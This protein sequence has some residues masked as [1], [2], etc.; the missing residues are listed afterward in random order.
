MG[1]LVFLIVMAILAFVVINAIRRAAAGARAAVNSGSTV[2]R[3]P[4]EHNLQQL[5]KLEA[6]V[7]ARS[8]ENPQLAELVREALEARGADPLREA[9]GIAAA[10]AAMRPSAPGDA[11]ADTTRR[12]KQ[13][14]SHDATAPAL[15]GLYGPQPTRSPLPALEALPPLG[16][17]HARAAI[18]PMQP[19]S[20][21][22]ARAAR[23]DQW[24]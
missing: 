19:L 22:A 18:A 9:L 1:G 2:R 15:A 14:H 16:A 5:Q 23:S 11:P 6:L 10:A 13:K 21:H 24:R 12:K 4:S 17:L 20:P 3:T 8:G 7:E